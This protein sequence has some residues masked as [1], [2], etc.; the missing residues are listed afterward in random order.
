MNNDIKVSVICLVYN[1]EKYLRQCLEG[2][3]NQ[4]T[5][6]DFEVLVHDD[7]STDNS[8]AIIKE[9]EEKYPNIIKPI[10]QKENQYSKGVGIIQT[11]LFPKARGK[12]LAFC[13]GDDYWCN[14][15][16]LQI[17]YDALENNKECSICT[18][19]VEFI[20]ENG[21]LIEGCFPEEQFNS[22]VY[23]GLTLL[24]N[25]PKYYFHTT[26]YFLRKED[27][28]KYCFN[29]PASKLSPVGDVCIMYSMF[30]AGDV[31]Y[32]DE[33]LSYYRRFA[34]GSWSVG[35]K[36]RSARNDNKSRLCD[37]L[38]AF[39]DQLAIRDSSKYE[40]CIEKIR[41][42][43]K[44]QKFW[45]YVDAEDYKMVCSEEYKNIFNSELNIAHK[46]LYKIL[47][48]SFVTK[49]I[50]AMIVDKIRK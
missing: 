5:N 39:C 4:K 21:E 27:L 15:N 44:R 38:G 6:F 3:V 23:S 45:Y 18:H 13:E 2:F 10:Y 40:S 19:K 14:E 20:K 24:A 34:N 33:T 12:Y 25:M 7:A 9:Y 48:Y 37:Y 8:K 42:E 46:V 41:T 36:K 16:K 50:Y 35:Q 17:Q 11:H 43:S 22:G 49:K 29:N 1:H 47:R 31:Y 32:I 30:V 26:S 28:E